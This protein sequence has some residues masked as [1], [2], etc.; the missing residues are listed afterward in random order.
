MD[1]LS[2]GDTC[3]DGRQLELGRPEESYNT[4]VL[5]TSMGPHTACSLWHQ[6]AGGKFRT[7]PYAYSLTPT[8]KFTLAVLEP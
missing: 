8:V 2:F 7:S 6:K 1:L 5:Y 4:T 3:V